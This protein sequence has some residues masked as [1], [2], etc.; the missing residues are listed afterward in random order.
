VIPKGVAWIKDR[1]RGIDPDQRQVTTGS[2]SCRLPRKAARLGPRSPAWPTPSPPP[3]HR[4]ATPPTSPRRPGNSSAVCAQVQRSSPCRPGPS[5]VVVRRRRS[6]TPPTTG[7]SQRE[8]DAR[9]RARPVRA[10]G[11]QSMVF[12]SALVVVSGGSISRDEHP[13]EDHMAVA[14]CESFP[15]HIRKFRGACAASTSMPLWR[16]R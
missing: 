11:T 1:A 10:G 14:T 4:A 3:T 12:P 7:A 13:V 9:K 8:P 15:R 16:F 5:N 6:P 2:G